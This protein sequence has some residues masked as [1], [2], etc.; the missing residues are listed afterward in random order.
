[1]QYGHLL[2]LA[3]V[4]M[5]PAA[6]R[7]PNSAH[8]LV[9]TRQGMSDGEALPVVRT[10]D[11]DGAPA[12]CSPADVTNRLS[13][14]F[15]AINRGD[16]TV[17]AEFYGVAPNVPFQWYS[18]DEYAAFSL[19]ELEAYLRERH[20]HQEQL[21]LERIQFNGWDPGRGLVHFGPLRLSRT[22]DDLPAGPHVVE[23]K[24]AFHCQRQTV[25]VLSLATQRH[26]GASS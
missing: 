14:M 21:Q 3:L 15:A 1:M 19:A 7:I 4:I 20:A 24:G 13:A 25:V 17:V 10:G 9:R 26:E 5:L 16:P 6:C 11:A 22:A 8:E 2:L 12:G 23:G 18:L